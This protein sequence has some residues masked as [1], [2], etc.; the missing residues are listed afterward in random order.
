[1]TLAVNATIVDSKRSGL[2]NYSVNLVKELAA[3][4]DD[5]IVFTSHDTPFVQP[6]VRIRK[7]VWNLAPSAGLQGHLARI[8]WTQT[9]LGI[10]ARRLE[11]SCLFSLVPEVP[12]WNSGPQVVVVHDLIPILFPK[13]YPLQN[14]YFRWYI[15]L[16]LRRVSKIIAVSQ[17]TKQDIV[18]YFSVNPS[19]IE[20]VSGGCD[21]QMF[22]PGINPD[23]VKQKYGLI[24]YIL[25]VGNLH[26][27]KNLGRLIEAFHQLLPS[28]SQQLVIVG[29]KDPRFFPGLGALVEKLELQ[30]RVVF[31]DFVPQKDLPGLYSGAELFVFP[32]LYEGFGLPLV[33]AMA[34]G[35]P[36]IAG[37]GGAIEEVVDK[38]G[39]TVDPTNVHEIA[40]AITYLLENPRVKDT[41]RELG[42]RQAK[43]FSW[44]AS[45]GLVSKVLDESIN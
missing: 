10:H 43:K 45:A 28:C 44:H 32:S 24:S 17:R 21:H 31:L 40:E 19:V 36:V 18:S 35:V 22:C 4:R 3:L 33:E 12:L 29:A 7:S 8:L 34:C 42:F 1:M 13:E 30:H 26:P 38:A 16:A 2:G 27:H 23:T 5:I 15:S 6:N 39:V 20:V 25:Y 11:A 41:L 9:A 37:T 14:L